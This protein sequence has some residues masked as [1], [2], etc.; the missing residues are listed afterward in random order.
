MPHTDFLRKVFGLVK[1]KFLFTCFVQLSDTTK[2]YHVALF[3]TESQVRVV[4]KTMKKTLRC[5]IKT[6]CK[7]KRLKVKSLPAISKYW[8]PKSGFLRKNMCSSIEKVF[9]SLPFRKVSSKI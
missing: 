8:E 6:A 1:L 4:I 9:L 7:K 5:L 2:V 3:N